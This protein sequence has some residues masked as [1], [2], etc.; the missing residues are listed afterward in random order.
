MGHLY[1]SERPLGGAH[2]VHHPK[3]DADHG[4]EGKQPANGIAPPWVHI[5]VVVL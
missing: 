1:L 2:L 5:L 4:G 3:W